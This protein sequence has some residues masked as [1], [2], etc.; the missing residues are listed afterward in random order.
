LHLGASGQLAPEE[1]QHL[2]AASAAMLPRISAGW[3]FSKLARSL[4][5]MPVACSLWQAV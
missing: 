2:L 1:T 4:D 3:I 5:M